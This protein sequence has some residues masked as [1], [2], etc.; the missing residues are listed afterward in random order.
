MHVDLTAAF[1]A[2]AIIIVIDH[3]VLWQ[4]KYLWLGH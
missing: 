4:S 1:T 3:S 2:A